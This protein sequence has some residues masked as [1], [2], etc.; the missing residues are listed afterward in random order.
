MVTT[1]GGF[2]FT[3][4]VS[5]LLIPSLAF[6]WSV[7][8]RDLANGQNLMAGSDIKV[9][10]DGLYFES[11]SGAGDAT[12]IHGLT[13]EEPD[14]ADDGKY[15]QYTHSSTSWTLG[16]PAGGGDM[17]IAVWDG[18]TNGY[19]DLD[20]GG[21][22]SYMADPNADRMMGWDDS[23]S[24]VTW[25]TLS[26][27]LTISGTILTLDADLQAIS[28][29]TSAA[30]AIPYFTGSG[31][32]SVISSS[33]NMVSLL[34][35]ADYATA[36][37]NLGLAIG[38]NVQAY[39]AELAAVA[40][41]TFADASVIQL[42]GAAAAAVLTSGGTN[43]FLTSTNDNSALEFKT[44]AAAL[45]AIGAQTLD[46][47]LTAIA[48]LT[49]TRGDLI[50]GSSSPAWTE[51]AIGAANTVLITDGTDPSWGTVT[52]AMITN[53]TITATD[54]AATLTF[55]ATDSVDISGV[56]ITTGQDYGLAIP[57]W[58]DVVPATDTAWIA[59][60]YT[61]NILK[62]Y[63]G[64]WVSISPSGA[65]TD[66]KYWVSTADA[67]LSA[68]V[69]LGLLTSGLVYSSVAASTSTP[70]IVS[71]GLAIDLTSSS[72]AFDPTELTGA[73]TW[74]AGG[75]ATIAWTFDVS[76]GTDPVVTFGNNYVNV[77]TGA[78]QVAGNAA[79]Y[80]S[81]TDVAV[82]DGGTNK[83]SWTQY[84]IPYLST[85]TAFS[86]I[87][88]G[89]AGQ[90]LIVNSGA[91]GYQWTA[92]L[93]M[94]TITDG[95]S[96]QKVAAADVDASSHV[97]RFYDS[98]GV[99]YITVTGLSTA[100]AITLEDAAQEL[101]ARNLANTFTLANTFNGNVTIGNANTD[102]LT[103]QSL[104]AGSGR[105]V[106]I[107]SAS[108][109]PTYATGVTEFYVGGDI[110]T[111]ANIYAA[112]FVGGT[113]TDGQR[114]ITLT[115]NTALTPTADQIYFIADVLYFSQAGTQKTP[116]RLEDAQT[117]SGLKTFEAGIY[118]GD[119]D[120]TTVFRLYDG[121]TNYVA[122]AVPA[123]SANYT[124]T[125]PTTDGTANQALITDGDGGLSWSTMTATAAGDTAGM[126]QYNA[127]GTEGA[128]AGDACFIFTVASN[129]LTLG[130]SGD[131]TTGS[132]EL[133]YGGTTYAATIVPSA[134]MSGDVTITLPSS[135]A[136]LLG[137]GANTYTGT[138][139]LDDGVTDSPSLVFTDATDETAT[140]AKVDGS[141]LTITTLAA[142]G[143]NILVGN[144]KVGNGT[145]GVT[146]DGEDVYIEGTLEVDGVARFDSGVTSALV[147][148]VTD[149]GALGSGTLMWSDLYLASG[150]VIN[151]NNGASTLTHSAN[152]L[153]LG[154]SGATALALGSNNLTMTGSLAATGSRITKGWF[155]DIESTNV[156]TVGGVAMNI[157]IITTVP[158]S[159][160]TAFLTTPS[161]AN[162]ATAVTGETGSGALVFAESPAL[163]TPNLGTPSAV[164]LTNAT[165]LPVATGI[166]GTASGVTDF[167]VTPS[168]ANFATAVTGETGSGALM[169]GTSPSVTTSILAVSNAD[170]GSS[171]A[172]F[173]DVY[174]KD[175]AV[176]KGQNDQSATLTSS[177]S[178][179]TANNF[180]VTGNLAVTGQASGGAKAYS[181]ESGVTNSTQLNDVTGVS[182]LLAAEVSGTIINIDASGVTRFTLPTP[183]SGY[184][185]IFAIGVSGVTVQVESG[186]TMYVDGTAT[187]T[188]GVGAQIVS[189]TPGENITCY[190]ANV[191]GAGEIE[192][193]CRKTED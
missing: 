153:T 108:P 179:W 27:G 71:E 167:L 162:L 107:D 66:A 74:A 77:S 151:F 69:N 114:G 15:M 159:G 133:Y 34:G 37:T 54:L 42:T 168:S 188:G 2:W 4:I 48:A 62:I 5:L 31:T 110:E 169:F 29:V 118:L 17:I 19:I 91:T 141:F 86:E 187:A 134:S 9:S 125:L 174:L 106:T 43:Y 163:T 21:T 44:P 164:V 122:I 158:G 24:G 136:T 193:M 22:N 8:P 127:T 117:V 99:G 157:N 36:R 57:R 49:V 148:A 160:V 33:A 97:N 119:T 98:D 190:T 181:V 35:S 51:L 126:V 83:S 176:I 166:S 142:D 128:L 40:G 175:G 63:D 171:S 3:L 39:D 73:R 130:A 137:T 113:G 121:S 101:A 124:L 76:T 7:R 60:D 72:I 180:A 147:P 109:S 50:I 26:T 67:T 111:A 155:T 116:M 55:A 93:T 94:D 177:A 92:A 80:A 32:A 161:S 150:G 100:R 112:S 6:G 58:A 178:L 65:P 68:E 70:S 138:Q 82:A 123:I 84:A 89:T 38:T 120:T 105:A 156:P 182:T 28:G 189:V 95:S 146:L 61:N 144:L 191:P 10:S 75:D 172:E 185:T 140:L 30:N 135:T 46:A 88:V 20:A 170:I 139:T 173:G 25:F 52:S 145:P 90:Y 81:G 23:A 115:S 184:N 96:Y 56:T 53:D 192:W 132:L 41:L 165:G 186:T 149:G 103:V 45:T 47:D 16:T 154:G 129:K 1:K 183:A 87:A 64:G 18:D 85:T 12:T 14:A 79:Y 13:V 59:W 131:A 104:I 152:T 11:S 102:T 143:V 78:L